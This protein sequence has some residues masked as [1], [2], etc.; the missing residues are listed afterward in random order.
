MLGTTW[1]LAAAPFLLYAVAVVTGKWLR[2]KMVEKELSPADFSSVGVPRPEE[3]KI[4]GTAVI[5]G[6]SIAGMLA[7]RVC[8][9][10]FDRVVIV[11]AEEW[12]SGEDGCNPRPCTQ[13]HRRSRVGQYYSTQGRDATDL[14]HKP[15]YSLTQILPADFQIR[16][17]GH[18]SLVPYHL[19]SK[20]ARTLYASRQGLETLI[21]RLLLAC[22]SYPNVK[23]VPGTVTGVAVDPQADGRL[24]KVLIHAHDG[25]TDI[26]AALVIDCTGVSQ[27]GSKWLRR[28]GY[29]CTPSSDPNDQLAV[30][31]MPNVHYDSFTF[32]LTPDIRA[33]LPVP[34]GYENA[35]CFFAVIANSEVDNRYLSA[36]QLE[37]GRLMITVGAWSPVDQLPR[38]LHDVK[39]FSRSLVLDKPIPE[40]WFGMLDM[41]DGCEDTMECHPFHVPPSKYFRFHEVSHLPSNFIAIGD[42]LIHLN[43][44]FGHGIPSTVLGCIALNK[45][46]NDLATWDGTEVS[47]LPADFSRRFFKAQW[48][49]V[50]QF[51]CVPHYGYKTTKPST[52]ESLSVGSWKRFYVHHFKLL[53]S[54]D[55]EVGEVWWH[56]AMLLAPSIDMFHPRIVLKVLFHALRGGLD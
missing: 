41:L 54:K 28:A 52:G 45:S 50:E 31:Y 43:P 22:N 20:I 48:R 38:T 26:D 6:G 17:R 40:W 15:A 8:H 30:S 19:G 27:A 10:H 34:G 42:S 9:D 11:E 56:T 53:S 46:L 39:T 44:V 18:T 35:G 29:D 1:P 24:Q 16:M 4:K 49:K 55:V 36:F 21:R 5:C 51:W 12:L 23:W 13:K 32:T 2:Q 33:R 14:A 7:A 25:H 37:S 3:K 47:L